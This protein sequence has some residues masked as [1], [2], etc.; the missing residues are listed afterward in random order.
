MSAQEGLDRD[1]GKDRPDWAPFQPAS[2]SL[3]TLDLKAIGCQGLINEELACWYSP[4]KFNS[5]P[6]ARVDSF[7]STPHARVDNES[8]KTSNYAGC[9][10]PN[11]VA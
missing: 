1:R 11:S 6:H 2:P 4:R 8:P 9:F 5:T 10:D 7:N 3:L